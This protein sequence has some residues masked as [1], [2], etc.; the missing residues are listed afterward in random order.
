MITV[1][2]LGCGN[3][4][5]IIAAGQKNFRITAVY[6]AVPA[7]VETFAHEFGAKPFSN[8]S[9]FLSES[10]DIVVEAASIVAVTE[11]AQDV[12]KSGKD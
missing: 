5:R 4:G 12:L 2:L 7:R 11:H 3:I 8:F 10:T 9:A 6:D 1:G